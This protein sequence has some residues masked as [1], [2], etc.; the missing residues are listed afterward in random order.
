MRKPIRV[1]LVLVV[2]SSAA[3]ALVAQELLPIGGG[4]SK[5]LYPISGNPDGTLKCK[6]GCSVLGPCC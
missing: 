3:G 6:A 5:R 2:L 1:M 4:D